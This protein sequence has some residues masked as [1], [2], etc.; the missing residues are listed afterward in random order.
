MKIYKCKSK[1]YKGVYWRRIN[2]KKIIW[3]ASGSIKGR[4]FSIH[5]ETE[6]EA[7]FKY[8]MKMIENN[9]EPVNVLVRK[10]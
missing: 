10:P 5:T 7:A 3:C 8:D 4:N 6:R 2:G 9:K 1:L